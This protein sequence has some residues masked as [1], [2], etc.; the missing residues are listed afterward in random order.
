MRF[1]K[2]QIRIQCLSF[3]SVRNITVEDMKLRIWKLFC[4]FI[5]NEKF[6]L[7]MCVNVWPAMN[8]TLPLLKIP[9]DCGISENVTVSL[10]KMYCSLIL[11]CGTEIRMQRDIRRL[12]IVDVML[13][14][15]NK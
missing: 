12:N 14:S 4:G 10:Y 5:E 1:G 8:K 3:A 2:V 7:Y 6:I 15:I 13:W 11:T 9:F